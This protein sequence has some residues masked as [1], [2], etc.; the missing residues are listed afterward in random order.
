[1]AVNQKVLIVYLLDKLGEVE[2]KCNED[3]SLGVGTIL[4]QVDSF[5]LSYIA[6]K[7]VEGTH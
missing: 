2:E 5:I 4:E 3:S 6:E 1:M 7:D